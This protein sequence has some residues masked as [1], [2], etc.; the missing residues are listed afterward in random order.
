MSVEFTPYQI[1]S[2]FLCVCV[3]MHKN[4][5]I[6]TYFILILSFIY[7]DLDLVNLCIKKLIE[8]CTQEID[9]NYTYNLFKR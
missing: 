1:K 5:L 8:M 9:Q 4:P 7:I 2:I 6:K 3:Q